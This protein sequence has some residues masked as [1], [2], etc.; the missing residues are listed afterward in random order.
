MAKVENL[1]EKISKDKNLL[2]EF[3]VV[4]SRCVK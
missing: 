2:K 1:F 3:Q 4:Q